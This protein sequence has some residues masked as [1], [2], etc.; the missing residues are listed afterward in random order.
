VGSHWDKYVWS[1]WYNCK[2]HQWKSSI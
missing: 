1:Q 2:F